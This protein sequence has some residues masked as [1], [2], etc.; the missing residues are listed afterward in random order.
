[1]TPL[2]PSDSRRHFPELSQTTDPE[3]VAE[4]DAQRLRSSKAARPKRRPRNPHVGVFVLKP[5]RWHPYYRLRFPNP[6]YDPE[7]PDSKKYLTEALAN[8]QRNHRELA[9]AKRD[10]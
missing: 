1:M 2:L 8:D 6:D 7:V 4:P 3:I 10:E 9:I 5:D